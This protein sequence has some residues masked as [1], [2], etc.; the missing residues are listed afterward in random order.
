[1]ALC[2]GASACLTR[3][4]PHTHAPYPRPQQ[5]K[6]NVT[7]TKFLSNDAWQVVA[8]ADPFNQGFFAKDTV[9]AC[10]QLASLAAAAA[11]SA[12]PDCAG[13][14]ACPVWV[15]PASLAPRLPAPHDRLPLTRLSLQPEGLSLA[16]QPGT[17]V[18]FVAYGDGGLS[19]R[20]SVRRPSADGTRW[21][22]VGMRAQYGANPDINE[23]L[24]RDSITSLSFSP[25]GRP[26][27][28]YQVRWQLG[29]ALRGQAGAAGARARVRPTFPAPLSLVWL[30]CSA[31]R[32]GWSLSVR[33]WRG[34]YRGWLGG[35]RA[36]H[37]AMCR[38]LTA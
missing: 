32:T 37:S 11:L 27:V 21:E 6:Q 30:H 23:L 3:D 31:P 15:E 2:G 35:M 25:A 16:V 9:S 36:A 13:C 20:L 10:L 33:W 1:M 14:P 17:G 22:Y 28:A 4:C 24:L 38:C 26:T 19:R 7:G 18:P 29:Q 5:V 34:W 12:A 8:A